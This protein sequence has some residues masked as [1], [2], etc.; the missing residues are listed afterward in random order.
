M[1]QK[2]RAIFPMVTQQ[3]RNTYADSLT[4]NSACCSF[5]PTNA[6]SG[7]QWHCLLM[8]SRPF[9]TKGSTKKVGPCI[10]NCMSSREKVRHLVP[11]SK[12]SLFP[13]ER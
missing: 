10:L 4:L 8:A 9:A 12:A 13:V 7:L 2:G 3:G 5:A 11:Q 1:S 6:W